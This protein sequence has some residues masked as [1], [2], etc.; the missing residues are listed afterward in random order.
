MSFDV[1]VKCK[2]KKGRDHHGRKDGRSS[3][4]KTQREGEGDIG[5]KPCDRILLYNVG[6]KCN[7]HWALCLT[8]YESIPYWVLCCS[9]LI[10]KLGVVVMPALGRV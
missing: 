7:K 1:S 3:R 10:C 5:A 8:V 9:F 6:G 4:S 2:R